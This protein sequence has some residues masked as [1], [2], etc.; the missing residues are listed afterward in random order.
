MRLT[1]VPDDHL[2]IIDGVS[3]QIDMS[4]IID[5]SIHAVQWY[6]TKGQI[7][8]ITDPSTG[9]KQPNDFIN[10]IDQFDQIIQLAQAAIAAAQQPA[11]TSSNTP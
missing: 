5:P 9:D 2:V 7:E 4:G 1:I 3:T 8:Y 10:S 6:N 11:N